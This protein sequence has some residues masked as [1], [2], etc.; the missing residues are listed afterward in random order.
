MT[1]PTELKQIRLNIGFPCND[2]GVDDGT[3]EFVG[4]QYPDSDYNSA[5]RVFFS[6]IDIL[7]FLKS[8]YAHTAYRA[9][10][11]LGPDEEEAYGN[12]L[13]E[14]I[15]DLLTLLAEENTTLSR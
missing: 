6:T 7:E 14:A 15:C 4:S 10:Q 9:R 8:Q 3:I 2:E 5:Q 11:R 1:T 13:Y 12:Q